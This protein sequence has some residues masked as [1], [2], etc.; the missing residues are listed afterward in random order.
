MHRQKKN[1]RAQQIFGTKCS[2]FVYLL[3][4]SRVVTFAKT[5][6]F[7]FCLNIISH[8]IQHKVSIWS[9]MP[10]LRQPAQNT[11][12]SLVCSTLPPSLSHWSLN[13]YF[14]W[15]EIWHEGKGKSIISYLREAC[16]SGG[17]YKYI[18][19]LGLAWIQGLPGPTGVESHAE[20]CGGRDLAC[21]PGRSSTSP[22][23]KHETSNM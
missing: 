9:S 1:R 20:H 7:H 19:R 2:Y 6:M 12:P 5:E 13:Q 10:S 23:W 16:K 15:L 11:A 4:L 8:L 18:F 21:S 3:S 17:R 22:L 14:L